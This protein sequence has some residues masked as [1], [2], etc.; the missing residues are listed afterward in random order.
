MQRVLVDRRV[1]VP[2]VA[3]LI[4]AMPLAGLVDLVNGWGTTP[5]LEAGEQ[6]WP[7]PP[8]NR[9]TGRLGVPLPAEPDT[10]EAATQVADR[11][12]P[13]FAAHNAAERVSLV[14]QLLADSNVR[15]FLSQPPLDSRACWLVD[16]PEAGPLAA[17]AVALRAQLA[18]HAPDRLGTCTGTRC[19]DIYIDASPGGHRRFC[20][21]TCQNRAR[22][23]NFRSRRANTT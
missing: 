11:L 22:I 5:R 16:V 15:P 8:L 17:A 9:L 1:T 3:V 4:E 19:A 18:A 13:V 12:H 21:I 7:Y 14:N 23:A 10:H 2:G 20:S 6:D